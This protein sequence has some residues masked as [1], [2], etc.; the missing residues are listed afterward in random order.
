M[1]A[2]SSGAAP[3]NPKIDCFSSPTANIVRSVSRA[4]APAKNSPVIART[5][6]H[7]SALLSWASSIRTWSIPPSSLN[8]TQGA[9]SSTRR[10]AFSIRSS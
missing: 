6:A 1:R 3:W 5:I 8:S 9:A 4:A 7:W 10:R 2:N